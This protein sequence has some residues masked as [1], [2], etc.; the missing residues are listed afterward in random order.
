M[1]RRNC[2]VIFVHLNGSSQGVRMLW[3]SVFTDKVNCLV[4]LKPIIINVCFNVF[5]SRQILL[6]TLYICL[7]LFQ[8]KPEWSL[9]LPW[10]ALSLKYLQYSLLDNCNMYFVMYKYRLKCHVKLKQQCE[11]PRVIIQTRGYTNSYFPSL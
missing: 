9:E 8:K 6:R 4:N 2:A 7:R 10:F 3:I 11:F 5:I 1:I